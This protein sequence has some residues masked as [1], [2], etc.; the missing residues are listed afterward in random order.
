MA[1]MPAGAADLWE[2][3]PGRCCCRVR[4][5]AGQLSGC[6]SENGARSDRHPAASQAGTWQLR[7]HLQHGLVLVPTL[8][9]GQ[10]L[11]SPHRPSTLRKRLSKERSL[12]AWGALGSGIIS[13]NSHSGDRHSLLERPRSQS[14]H[15]LHR[16]DSEVS[17]G[18]ACSSRLCPRLLRPSSSFVSW[19]VTC[20]SVAPVHARTSGLSTPRSTIPAADWAP[21]RPGFC[22][23]WR[24]T[25]AHRAHGQAGLSGCPAQCPFQQELSC[26]QCLLREAP[27]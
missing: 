4:G 22:S 9:R 7:R 11:K 18:E 16:P 5:V 19:L 21:G 23:G 26:F 1:A 14:P 13:P 24:S 20:P 25:A 10:Q 8:K 6:G 17:R 27:L 15:S 12:Q 3:R 2:G